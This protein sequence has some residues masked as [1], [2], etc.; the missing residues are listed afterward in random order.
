MPRWISYVNWRSG[1]LLPMDGGTS[2]LY[3]RK[4]LTW[5]APCDAL[6]ERI[7]VG[8]GRGPG[9]RKET[10]AEAEISS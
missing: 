2:I 9:E 3:G 5:Y 1:G 6:I 4:A 8:Q 10:N 7:V